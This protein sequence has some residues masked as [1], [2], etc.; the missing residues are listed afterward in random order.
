MLE[1]KIET[2]WVEVTA[3]FGG[4]A[5]FLRFIW[6]KIKEVM[7]FIRMSTR[8]SFMESMRDIASSIVPMKEIIHKTDCVHIILI[9]A[10][11]S[12]DPLR[13]GNFLYSSALYEDY[14]EGEEP[15]VGKWTNQPLDTNY[16]EILY[17]LVKR[18]TINIKEEDLKPGPLKDLYVS[19]GI[20]FSKLVEICISNDQTKYI[21]ISCLFKKSFEELTAA[22]RDQIRSSTQAIRNIYVRNEY[23]V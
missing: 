16:I 9:K 18:K 11:N 15:I 6:P 17:N 3:F 7:Y 4:F 14:N 12:G 19:K 21:Y 23:F 20:K 13:L 2:F 1:G 8:K 10:H 5:A 22:E